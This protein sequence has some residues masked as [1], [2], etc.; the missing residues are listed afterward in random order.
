MRKLFG[1]TEKRQANKIASDMAP[2][3]EAFLAYPDYQ[4]TFKD[5]AFALGYKGDDN[6]KIKEILFTTNEEGDIGF[7]L[8]ELNGMFQEFQIIFNLSSREPFKSLLENYPEKKTDLVKIAKKALKEGQL[9][10]EDLEKL[11]NV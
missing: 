9:T 7:V 10:N 3:L 4:E 6:V 8:A 11:F 1:M 5:M 2:V